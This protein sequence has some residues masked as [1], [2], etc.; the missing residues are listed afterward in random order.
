LLFNVQSQTTV[1]SHTQCYRAIN[2]P[3]KGGLYDPQLALLAVGLGC[4]ICDVGI[5]IVVFAVV[6][7]A[8]V[9][10]HLA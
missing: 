5:K 3:S 7:D 1:R 4:G 8:P 10:D 6:Q 9:H 2:V